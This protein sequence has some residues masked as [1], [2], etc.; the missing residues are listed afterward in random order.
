MQAPLTSK[1]RGVQRKHHRRLIPHT[2]TYAS[3]SGCGFVQG[4]GCGGV[5]NDT[6]PVRPLFLPVRR[7]QNFPECKMSLGQDGEARLPPEPLFRDC[8]LVHLASKHSLTG[9]RERRELPGVTGLVQ[10]RVVLIMVIADRTPC[11]M[12]TMIIMMMVAVRG[13]R[14]SGHTY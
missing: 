10:R 14:A 9:R 4:A 6:V 11:M 3:G 7:F 2:H 13:G 12:V 8:L 1:P 5:H